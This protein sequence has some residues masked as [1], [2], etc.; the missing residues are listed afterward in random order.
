MASADTVA[1]HVFVGNGSSSSITLPSL[2]IEVLFSDI[3]IRNVD[4][5]PGSRVRAVNKTK[6]ALTSWN[7]P[8]SRGRQIINNQGNEW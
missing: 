4:N 2:F 6:D 1:T 3:G 7:G 8:S 5:V